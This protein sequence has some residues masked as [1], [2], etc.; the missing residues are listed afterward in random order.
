MM[1]R[2]IAAHFIP[3]FVVFVVATGLVACGSDGVQTKG[4]EDVPLY[5]FR[6]GL[7]AGGLPADVAAAIE[8]AGDDDCITK[9]GSAQSL[10]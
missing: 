10:P 1:A 6:A 5:P 3:A 9:P 8:Q 4:C 7:D 2:S